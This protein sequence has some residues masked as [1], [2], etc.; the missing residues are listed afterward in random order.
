MDYILPGSSHYGIFLGK[1]FAI[2]FS[3]ESSQPRA[4]TQ[5]SCTVGRFFTDWA[6]REANSNMSSSL[7][8]V[9]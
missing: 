7:A 4:W 9:T 8:D 6:T 3:R 5:L 1:W 2:S